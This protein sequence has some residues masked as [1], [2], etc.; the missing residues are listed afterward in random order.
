MEFSNL[1]FGFVERRILM[2]VL[3]RLWV[4]MHATRD[5][6]LGGLQGGRRHENGVLV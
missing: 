5:G 3:P 6:R 4:V 1:R 2:E